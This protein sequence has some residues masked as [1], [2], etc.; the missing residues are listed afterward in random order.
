MGLKANAPYA[1][2]FYKSQTITKS[3]MTN[4]APQQGHWS[5]WYL[6]MVSMDGMW[7]IGQH[8]SCLWSPWMTYGSLVNMVVA[9]GV[10]VSPMDNMQVIGQHGSF[11]W[12]PWMTCGSLVNMVVAYGVMAEH[13]GKTMLEEASSLGHLDSIFVLGMMLMDEGRNRKQEALDMLNNAYRIT[14]DSYTALDQINIKMSNTRS[15]RSLNDLPLEILS[16]IFV[17]LGAES[18]KDIVFARL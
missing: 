15:L 4:F 10:I 12:C 16:R 6:L 9:Y 1:S 11:L 14:K 17:V 3:I 2:G 7:V 5:T 8:G 13:E 18:V